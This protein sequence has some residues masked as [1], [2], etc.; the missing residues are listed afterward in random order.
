M[1][2]KRLFPLLLRLDLLLLDL[3]NH[4][5]VEVLLNS[6]GVSTRPIVGKGAMRG[7]HGL[8]QSRSRILDCICNTY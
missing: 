7:R 5:F 8:S 3:V 1:L 6:A 2:P 4:H